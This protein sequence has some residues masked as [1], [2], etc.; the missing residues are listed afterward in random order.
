MAP[1]WSFCILMAVVFGAAM[2]TVTIIGMEH[3]LHAWLTLL[4]VRKAVIADQRTATNRLLLAAI[5]T[6]LA[7]SRRYNVML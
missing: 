1:R 6:L 2:P 3:M 7:A 4:F 5:A